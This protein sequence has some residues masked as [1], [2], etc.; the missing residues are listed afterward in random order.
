MFKQK[1]KNII[2]IIN[3][4]CW[5]DRA[6]SVWPISFDVLVPVEASPLFFWSELSLRT[7]RSIWHRPVFPSR[8][9]RRG[10]GL[11][12]SLSWQ[13]N[14]TREGTRS[15]SFHHVWRRGFMV[16]NVLQENIRKMTQQEITPLFFSSSS[17]TFK[18][19]FY[20]LTH[21]LPI[22]SFILYFYCC[23][24]AWFFFLYLFSF[25]F[26][27]CGSVLRFFSSRTKLIGRQTGQALAVDQSEGSYVQSETCD[28]WVVGNRAASRRVFGS[29]RGSR[30]PLT[31]RQTGQIRTWTNEASDW[32]WRHDMSACSPA[33]T[34]PR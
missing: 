14:Q 18:Q 8:Q 13:Q 28:G 20:F 25:L 21:F 23:C 30:W 7:S 5:L 9:Q 34:R 22:S 4:Y 29:N 17:F 1:D 19:I 33:A 16:F 3:Y 24:T 2:I 26:L 6:G 10:P 11:E 15:G 31:S 12:P 32:S 27:C